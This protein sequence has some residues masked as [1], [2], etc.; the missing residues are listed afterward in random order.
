M[1][2]KKVSQ[3]TNS[4]TKSTVASAD[5]FPIVD[6]STS[7]TK[8]IT[9]QELIQPQDDQFSISGS[10]DNT[11]KVRF[12]VDGV[13]T[14]TT[15]VVSVPDADITMVG[16]A[17]TQTL[18]N[19]TLTSP[20]I[21]GATLTTSSVNG[22]TL[23]TSAGSTNYLSG[24]G[25]YSGVTVS[26]ATYATTGAV[27]G[28]TD[29]ATSGLTIS[30]GVISVNSGTAANQIVK[31]NGSAQLP[32]VDGSLLTSIGVYKN[33]STTRDVSDS[34]GTQTIAHGVGKTPRYV[35][36]TAVYDG[37]S[38][39]VTNAYTFYNGTTQTSV[40]MAGDGVNAN[41]V[42]TFCLNDPNTPTSNNRTQIGV[43]TYD[44]TNISIAWTKSGAGSGT[45][46]LLWEAIA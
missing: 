18:T 33:G 46:T 28:L 39:L 31:L 26:N 13:T 20:T 9:Y 3:L 17:T 38:T 21:T 12:E 41:M 19:K 30:S 45:Y 27:Q 36:I 22:I 44:A 34:S 23:S 37:G 29:A 25:T 2:N 8:K 15:R 40:G 14:G 42:S 11:K 24:D 1:A 5:I 43:L 32:A 7:E 16:T 10:V 6:T 35:K 4:L